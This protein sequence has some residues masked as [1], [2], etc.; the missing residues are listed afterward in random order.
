MLLMIISPFIYIYML[1]MIISPFI[2]INEQSDQGMECQQFYLH[3]LDEIF[4]L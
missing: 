1:L 3:L 2:Y 4:F